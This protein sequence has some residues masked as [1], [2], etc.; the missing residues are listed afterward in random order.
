MRDASNENLMCIGLI[1]SK[2]GQV[3]VKFRGS[4]TSVTKCALSIQVEDKHKVQMLGYT[5]GG[6][7]FPSYR[8][9]VS[10][11]AYRT[12]LPRQ[13][14]SSYVAMILNIYPPTYISSNPLT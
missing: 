14:P 1:L 8:E 6:D 11:S 4:E 5:H 13:A 10:A 3:K 2:G 9:Y 7:P 12:L